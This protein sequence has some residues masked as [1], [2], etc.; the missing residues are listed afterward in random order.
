MLKERGKLL[1]ITCSIFEEENRDVIEK[2]KKN[3]GNVSE[4]KINFPSNVAHIKNQI[5]PSSNHD[6]LFYALL[7]KN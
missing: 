7:Q 4:L 6:G 5:L 1:Y 2:F 3:L